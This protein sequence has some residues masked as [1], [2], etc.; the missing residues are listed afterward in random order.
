MGSEAVWLSTR[1]LARLVLMAAALMVAAALFVGHFCVAPPELRR[2]V[3]PQYQTVNRH[4]FKPDP[5]GLLL[6]N[7]DRGT[8]ERIA[9]PHADQFQYGSWSPWRDRRG[10]AQVV[11]LWAGPSG[12]GSSLMMGLIRYAV[13]GWQVIDRVELDCV[14]SSPPCWFPDMTA[15]V[16]FSGWDG[17]L[18]Q[19]SFES[20]K[21]GGSGR[22]PEGEGVLRPL[23]WKNQPPQRMT[24]IMAPNWPADPRLKGRILASLTFIRPNWREHRF[25]RETLSQLWWL[26]LNPEGT[27]IEEAGPLVTQSN[28]SSD[29]TVIIED[30][31][32]CAVAPDG[33]AVLAYLT[34]DEFESGYRLRLAPLSIDD[35]T[36]IP[37]LDEALAVDLVSGLPSSPPAFSPDGRWV[38]VV[39][40]PASA[41]VRVER[42]SVLD[43]LAEPR[44]HLLASQGPPRL[45]RSRL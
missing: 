32:V 10:H 23:T 18:Y 4:L 36:G 17:R 34:R 45:P 12:T 8:T 5:N 44:S 13:P 11:G 6:L 15:R 38:H 43:A 41:S 27:V 1:I 7:A 24:L 25:R 16:I 29:E 19:F 37:S 20:L 2:P 39:A 22:D 30:Q 9:L 3:L 40:N 33:R 14:P 28:S 26:K 35:S 21:A 42:F 31:P